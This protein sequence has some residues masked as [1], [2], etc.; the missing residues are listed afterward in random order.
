[1]LS[2]RNPPS[3]GIIAPFTNPEAARLAK[4]N[5]APANSSAFPKRPKGVRSMIARPRGCQFVL[6]TLLH[7]EC[8]VLVTQE[9][10][11]GDRVHANPVG[12]ELPGRYPP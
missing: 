3:T 7:E 9:E 2:V 12:A 11:G 4:N 6:R 5:V 10:P 8:A 1:M